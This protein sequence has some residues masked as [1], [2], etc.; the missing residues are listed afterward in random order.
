MVFTLPP[1]I[2]PA[3]AVSGAV[4]KVEQAEGPAG[5]TARVEISLENPSGMSGGELVL[6]Y[7]PE[8]IKP[9]DAGRGDLTS[10]LAGYLFMSNLEYREDAIKIVWAGVK[11]QK[12][13]GTLAVLTFELMEQ[14]VSA[15]AVQGII[16]TDKDGR[17]IPVKVGD[18]AV[19]VAGVVE[20]SLPVWPFIAGPLLVSAFIILIIRLVRTKRR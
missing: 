4:L 7:D 16:L 8:T 6:M 2:C 18:G 13:D 17:H 11:S 9:V 5:G 10:I 14:G 1:F 19:N 15:L 3:A 12:G 20:D